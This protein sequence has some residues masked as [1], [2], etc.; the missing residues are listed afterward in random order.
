VILLFSEVVLKNH[1]HIKVIF[2][3]KAG[4]Y[5]ISFDNEEHLETK[6]NSEYIVKIA[7]YGKNF[8]FHLV[9]KYESDRPPKH[10]ETGF[11]YRYRRIITESITSLKP[12]LAL[13]RSFNPRDR[14]TDPKEI[15]ALEDMHPKLKE[16]AKASLSKGN[17]GN[18]R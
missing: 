14:I 8:H 10:E 6:T 13:Y 1:A 3:N 9:P 12:S 4:C 5:Y 7:E 11:S 17:S 15:D 16:L 18:S 2:K